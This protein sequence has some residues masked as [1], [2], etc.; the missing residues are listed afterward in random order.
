MIKLKIP[1]FDVIALPLPA[2][3]AGVCLMLYVTS[4]VAF[5]LDTSAKIE[6]TDK[7]LPCKSGKVSHL[8]SLGEEA[9]QTGD[10]KAAARSSHLTLKY[11]SSDSM[12]YAASMHNIGL[13]QLAERNY[14]GAAQSLETALRL[15]V[16]QFGY[17]NSSTLDTLCKLADALQ[18][19]RNIEESQRV[20]Q[21]GFTGCSNT[22]LDAY[23]VIVNN[24]L[25]VCEQK[26]DHTNGIIYSTV[27]L[28][29]ET[30]RDANS[31][32][33][34]HAM[35]RLA[36]AHEMAG[37]KEIST[38]YYTQVFERR[39][40]L[41]AFNQ[42][43]FAGVACDVGAMAQ[44]RGQLAEAEKYYIESLKLFST[45]DEP[46]FGAE[47]AVNLAQIY[48]AQGKKELAE[49]QL[50]KAV[51]VF[52]SPLYHSKLTHATDHRLRETL[53][54]IL[55]ELDRFYRETKQ[56]SKRRSILDRIQHI[57]KLG[58]IPN[59]SHMARNVP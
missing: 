9:F 17:N 5:G 13:S 58:E 8:F 57:R 19:G 29:I 45:S 1:N 44:I 39:E 46:A 37:N 22:N 35:R 7:L 10:Y 59:A 25:W 3:V 42:R 36:Q 32:G 38:A 54:F 21:E 14:L 26:N 11:L 53:L 52:D 4:I 43:F 12:D 15:K 16:A 27:L 6:L 56:D 47:P 18:Y 30:E 33:T 23:R 50:I 51:S 55:N 40:T 41:L 48:E 34:V 28:K 49:Q 31:F 2:L 20:L 24:L